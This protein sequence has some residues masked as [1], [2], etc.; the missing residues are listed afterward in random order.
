[1]AALGVLLGALSLLLHATAYQDR[2]AAAYRSERA[3]CAVIDYAEE[4][5]EALPSNPQASPEAIDRFKTLISDMRATGVDCPPAP[6]DP[7]R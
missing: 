1:M 5:L 3:I 2:N 6:P 4:T 7:L